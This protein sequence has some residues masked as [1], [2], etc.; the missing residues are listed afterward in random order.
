MSQARADFR[1]EARRAIE[2][3]IARL[4]LKAELAPG[5][6]RSDIALVALRGEK[7]KVLAFPLELLDEVPEIDVELMSLASS[8]YGLA[9]LS[10]MVTETLERQPMM[11]LERRAKLK[12]RLDAVGFGPE[13]G[14]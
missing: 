6:R 9:A 3:V 13:G 4:Q 14:G 7:A 11:P 2:R 12:R 10:L 1:A 5:R 8:P